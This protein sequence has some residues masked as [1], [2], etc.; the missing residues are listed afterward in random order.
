M[1]C[2]EP[3][4]GYSV[5]A[6]TEMTV[7]LLSDMLGDYRANHLDRLAALRRAY[8]GDHAILH[9]QAKA[10]YKPD[11]RL[12]ANYAKQ[13][14]DTMVGYFM[15]VPIRLASDDEKAL[16]A[17][18]EW[19]SY[20]GDD[21]LNAELSKLCD[22]YGSALEVMWRDEDARPQSSPLSP[23]NGFV[24]HDDTV[25]RRPLYA[26]TFFL[27]DNRFDGEPD[28]LRG[29]LYTPTHEVPFSDLGGIRLT[30]E[31]VPHGFPDVPVV[32]YV[33][34]EERRGLFEGVMSLIDAHEEAL[35]E[36]ANDVDYYADAYLKV[37]GAR[38]DG[39]T[40]RKLRDSRII[41]MEGDDASKVVVEFLAKPEAD[42]T[43]E[44]L[45]DRL[46]R[47]IFTLGMVADVSDEDFGTASGI[48][49]RYRL[50]AMSDLAMTKE[51]KFR[52]GLSRRWRLVLGY[53]GTTGVDP[54]A[55]MRIRPTFTRN[56][57]ANLLEESQIAQNL[58]G[59]TSAETQLSVLSCVDSPAEELRRKEEEQAGQVEA[60]TAPRQVR[61]DG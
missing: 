60:L 8:E 35:S 5:P 32:E 44:H 27:D 46:E 58:A 26:V 38:L 39:E 15:G 43:Q 47:L 30:G 45:I 3:Y 56:V 17:I 33:E 37:L 57:P 14:V 36:K 51:R 50:Q 49:I 61:T 22:I 13:M 23:M 31:P 10:E 28:A 53:A 24:V 7:G 11:N 9:R 52:K 41:N 18:E 54:D 6:G 4:L 40:L 12:V 42:A 34:N 19:N 59:I 1:E 55:W 29:T 25:A 21:D 2:Y 48:A 20:V 16:A